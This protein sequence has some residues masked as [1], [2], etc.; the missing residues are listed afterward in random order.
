M[1][2][3]KECHSTHSPHISIHTHSSTHNL[4]DS[5][6]AIAVSLNE[7]LQCTPNRWGVLRGI[8]IDINVN[9]LQAAWIFGLEEN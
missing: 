6:S 3:I 7:L 1:K 9:V 2:F 8:I 4:K 5:G